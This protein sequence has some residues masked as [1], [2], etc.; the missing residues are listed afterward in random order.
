MAA[1]P[2]PATGVFVHSH[3]LCESDNVGAGTRIWAFAHV[4]KG[5]CIGRDCNICDNVLVEGD[6]V[7]GDSVTIKSGVQLWDGVRLG[8][9]VFVGPNATFTNDL[10]PRSKRYPDKFLETI[11]EDGASIGA[12]A[13]ILAGIRIGRSAMIGAGAV[14][15]RSVPSHAVVVGNPGRIVGYDQDDSASGANIPEASSARRRLA[16]GASELWQMRH[17]VDMRGELSPMEFGSDLP[18]LPQRSFVVYGVPTADVRG[19]HAHKLCHQFLIAIHGKVT[20]TLNDGAQSDEVTLGEPTV[21][22]WLPPMVWATQRQFE[23]GT[24]LLVFASLPYDPDDYIRDYQA[25]REL[26]GHPLPGDSLRSED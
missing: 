7:I 3:G 8:N 21:G 13:T 18:F 16:V 5:A 1:N 14:V 2:A 20:V 4:L 15:T 9:N 17:Y 10:F 25:F 23:A 24:K 12:N 19:S 11:V 6:V 22:L 26:I